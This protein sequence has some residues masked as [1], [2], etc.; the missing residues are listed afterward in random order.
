MIKLYFYIHPVSIQV[1]TTAEE[2]VAQYL[3][4]PSEVSKS[5]PLAQ[6]VHD[7]PGV[8]RLGYFESEPTQITASLAGAVSDIPSS[9]HI[10]AAAAVL[11]TEAFTEASFAFVLALFKL[12]KTIEAKIPIIAITIK[13]S[14]KVK[15]FF[16]FFIYSP[17]FLF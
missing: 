9:A 14:I 2:F 1:I 11:D 17:R 6:A 4:V 13:S 5:S 3:N 7:P 8:D 15:P 16:I 12:T 10:M